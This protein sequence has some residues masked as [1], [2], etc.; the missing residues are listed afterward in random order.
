MNNEEVKANKANLGNLIL[1]KLREKDRSM[2]W[3]AGKVHCDDSN[4]SKT[5][6]SSQF[7]YFDLLLRISL[8]LEEDFFA[9]GSQLFKEAKDGKIHQ[10]NR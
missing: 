6:K 1:Q 4:L 2:A 8:A 9:Y 5:L 7:I 10:E 3:L